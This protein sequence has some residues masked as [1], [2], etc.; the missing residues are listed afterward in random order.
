M[1][2]PDSLWALPGNG[3]S[4]RAGAA[5]LGALGGKLHWLAPAVA[6]RVDGVL[7]I[8]GIELLGVDPC[9]L[10]TSAELRAILQ[11]REA[12]L[13][14]DASPQEASVLVLQLRCSA[15]AASLSGA[16]GASGEC[17]QDEVWVE[18]SRGFVMPT[19]WDPT[20]LYRTLPR[21]ARSAPGVAAGE[22][23]GKLAVRESR[24]HASRPHAAQPLQGHHQSTPAPLQGQPQPDE[25]RSTPHAAVQ[26]QQSNCG[27]APDGTFVDGLAD[28]Q[29]HVGQQLGALTLDAPD[30]V[31]TLPTMEAA[32]QEAL[33]LACRAFPR[34]GTQLRAQLAGVCTA[35]LEACRQ[36][37]EEQADG[38]A[39]AGAERSGIVALGSAVEGLF[40]HRRVRPMVC[41]KSEGSESGEKNKG[42]GESGGGS[43]GRDGGEGCEDGSASGQRNGT[44]RTGGA[45]S[46]DGKGMTGGKSK[47]SQ[48]KSCKNNDG[49]SNVTGVGGTGTVFAVCREAV[50]AC[51]RSTPQG[52]VGPVVILRNI[53]GHPQERF[54]G[55][56]ITAALNYC[57]LLR[58]R[59]ASYGACRRLLIGALSGTV[60]LQPTLVLDLAVMLNAAQPPLLQSP[61]PPP[62]LPSPR[63]L[64]QQYLQPMQPGVGEFA[65][66]APSEEVGPLA[67]AYVA[68]L[69]EGSQWRVAVGIALELSGDV[70]G[71]VLLRQLAVAGEWKT[72]QSLAL[73]LDKLDAHGHPRGSVSEGDAGAHGP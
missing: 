13:G 64:P 38:D 28:E 3:A 35:F 62:P 45:D 25:L 43:D 32:V 10:H 16:V 23:V 33:R 66:V 7:Q 30:G 63:Q 39:D 6:T 60:K 65:D 31:C 37:D 55:S 12:E 46:K 9:M 49:G 71:E 21:G 69:V 15:T 53:V 24:G 61:L 8:G 73:G 44:T 1:Q 58:R 68:S 27:W 34:I 40:Q 26:Q 42:G 54:I 2:F 72:A 17:D 11:A 67:Q 48:G 51:I 20:P 29:L 52:S 19:A 70:D 57:D 59:A 36:A 50:A 18:E 47:R 56:I 4:V 22:E 14:D 5:S 41:I